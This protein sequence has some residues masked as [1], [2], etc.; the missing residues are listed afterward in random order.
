MATNTYIALDKITTGSAV[1][2]VTFTSINQG[3]TDLV[4]VV[5]GTTN[6]GGTQGV[7]LQFN[8]DTGT[9]YSRTVLYGN[10]SSAASTRDSSATSSA[11]GLLDDTQGNSIFHIMNY[12]NT[13]TYKTALSRG[14]SAASQVRA[15]VGLWRSTAAITSMTVGLQANNIAAGTTFSLYGIKAQ[16]T[17][18]AAKATGGTITYD[19]FGRVIHTFTSS[20]TFTP[21]EP[22]TNVEYLV[23]AGGGGGGYNA[24]G[25]GGAGGY[26]TSA[27]GETSGGGQFAQSTLSLSATAY[28]V[29]VGAG[30]AGANGS[31]S[32]ARGSAGGNSLI[33]GSGITT[34][35]AIG[36]GGGGSRNGS[37]LDGGAGG[38]SGGGTRSGGGAGTRTASPIQGY[39]GQ[40]GLSTPPAGGGG[41]AGEAGGTDGQGDG[42]DGLTSSIT[43]SAVVRGGGGGGGGGDGSRVSAG[44]TGGGGAGGY[45]TTSASVA[46][47]AN[48]G[49][50]GGG[51]SNETIYVNGSAGGSGVVIIRYAG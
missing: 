45:S 16:V 36:G 13:T 42:G 30:G 24:G 6:A 35:T 19:N 32:A 29:E 44:G 12:S 3:Y 10:G 5:S 40:G 39:S 15:G 22:L 1:A 11:I 4:L 46:G 26:L 31:N 43:G 7:T 37:E 48:T 27:S 2:S 51:G 28:T 20:G 25:G 14:N 18:G 17:P 49:G 23:I 47:T 41:G 33:S 50:G 34:V 9:N 38:S 21:T 8:S